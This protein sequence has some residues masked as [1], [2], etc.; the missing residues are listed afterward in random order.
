MAQL[1]KKTLFL[2][3]S[4]FLPSADNNYTPTFLQSRVLVY[5]IVALLA[6]KIITVGLLIPFPKNIF[7]AD[8]TKIDLVNLLNQNRA[9]LGLTTLQ[10]NEKLNLAAE[11]KAKDMIGNGYFSH[12]SPKGVTP[13]AWFKQVD[14][15]YKYAGENLAVGFVDSK[16]VYDAWY[17]S[18]SHKANLLN[19]NYKEVGTAVVQGFG[20]NKSILIV[21]MFGNPVLASPAK[22]ATIMAAASAAPQNTPQ[23][24]ETA[25]PAPAQ[26]ETAVGQKV[27]G[28]TDQYL[29]A[30]GGKSTLYYRFLNFM[31]YDSDNALAYLSYA[32]LLLT[33]TCLLV[34]LMIE[35]QIERK[36]L[37][38]QSL[39]LIG[40]LYASTFITRELMYRVMPYQV[41]I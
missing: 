27:L 7:F 28:G 22:P 21:Q 29:K 6:V 11:L 12:N 3:K 36:K 31:I 26:N 18:S 4:A 38:V 20:E 40:I 32:I 24:Q 34:S 15:K 9:E 8:V 39:A 5:I 25:K 41:I 17:N 10:E 33:G 23:S 13:W 19:K 1:F 37:V 16:N 35:F 14:Y 30:N 2:L